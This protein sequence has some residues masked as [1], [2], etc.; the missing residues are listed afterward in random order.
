[1]SAFNLALEVEPKKRLQGLG[2]KVQQGMFLFS[3]LSYVSVCTLAQV[4]SEAR[5]ENE[6]PRIWS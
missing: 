4:P 2:P 3:L 5:K 6:I 1:M